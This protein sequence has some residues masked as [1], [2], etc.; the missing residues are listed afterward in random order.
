MPR[1]SYFCA[2][3][4]VLVKFLRSNLLLLA[5]LSFLLVS[6]G[7]SRKTARHN[8]ETPGKTYVPL[9]E[10]ALQK[11][12]ASR[13]QASPG[14]LDNTTLYYFID[15]WYGTPYRYGGNT[16]SGIDC[17][18]FTVQLYT[19]VFKSNL[20][21]TA[22]QQYES[23]KRVKKVKKLEEGDLVFFNDGRGR[24]SHVGVYLM[25]NFF[26][27]AGTGTGVIIGNL[28]DD[29]WRE[30]FVAGGKRK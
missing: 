20:P 8:T 3:S 9:S 22:R 14:D 25:N 28:E 2:I 27:H 23:S 1:I 5:A 10:K 21:R 7:A 4:L 24:I 26:V 12:Y 30:H 17:S 16:R 19:K 29:Y 15:E 18:G 13:L 11:K 6:C